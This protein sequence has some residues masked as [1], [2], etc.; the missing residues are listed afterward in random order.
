MVFPFS[1]SVL[2][3]LFCVLMFR[4]LFSIHNNVIISRGIWDPQGAAARTR[5]LTTNAS[6]F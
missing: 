3:L 5:R 4:L 6:G 2:L 1:C